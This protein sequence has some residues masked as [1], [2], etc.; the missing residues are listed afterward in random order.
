MIIRSAIVAVT[1]LLLTG[2]AVATPVLKADIVVKAG[3]VTVGDMFEGAG[4]AAEQPLFRAPEPGTSGMVDIADIDAALSRI[5]IEDFET[6]GLVSTRVT[7]AAAV[8]DA[9]LLSELIAA[10][11]TTRGII[12]DGMS[13][14][15]LFA[16]PVEPI[17]AEA[18]AEP[19]SVISLRYLPGSGAFTARFAIAG[20]DQPLDVSGSI[21]LMISVN[22]GRIA[23]SAP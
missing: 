15:T 8:V 12:G 3:I 13:V 10:D 2:A 16:V 6:Q 7:R 18:V 23:G 5:G 4:A 1:A 19:A 14:D 17:N 21:E 20:V 9:G 22:P 11:L